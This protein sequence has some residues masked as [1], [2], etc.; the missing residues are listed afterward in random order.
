M[1]LHVDIVRRRCH[2]GVRG[3]GFVKPVVVSALT[4]YIHPGASG[5]TS[6][7]LLRYEWGCVIGSFGK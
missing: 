6:S 1:I 5:L 7:V 3:G 4:L 2:L